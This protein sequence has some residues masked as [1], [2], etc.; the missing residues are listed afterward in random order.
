M[1]KFEFKFAAVLRQRKVREEE[2]LRALGRAQRAYQ[3]ELANKARLLAEL[4]NSLQRREN[5]GQVP[6]SPLAFQLEDEFISGSKHWIRRADQVILRASKA[7]EKALRAYL[8]ARRQTTMIERLREKA[9][10][11]YRRERAKYEQKQ[12]DDLAVM[13]NRFAS[14]TSVKEQVGASGPD[15]TV[16]EIA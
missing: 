5:L 16:E 8:T 4:E 9:Y 3:A 10:E 13:R 6:I 12:Q 1:K 2:S 11:E 14:P 15:G 7:V